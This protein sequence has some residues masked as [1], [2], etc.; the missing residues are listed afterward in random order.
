[1]QLLLL[2]SPSSGAAAL[3]LLRGLAHDA[4]A[5]DFAAAGPSASG[6][7]VVVLDCACSGGDAISAV[8]ALREIRA[9]GCSPAPYVL[10]INVPVDDRIVDTLIDAG[11][12]MSCRD[13]PP[14]QLCGSR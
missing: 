6:R 14:A 4:V 3:A 2:H 5:A 8:R 1:M 10:A 13:R 7:A 11:R 9:S 12:T